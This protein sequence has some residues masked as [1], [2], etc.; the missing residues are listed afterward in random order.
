[1]RQMR[2]V[3]Y[4]VVI[5]APVLLYGVAVTLRTL[6]PAKTI[7]LTSGGRH[8]NR[9]SVSSYPIQD[10]KNPCGLVCIALVSHLHQRPVSLT[11]VRRLVPPD[12]LGRTS[13]NEL[14][15]GL[16]ALGFGVVG[17]KLRLEACQQLSVPLIIHEDG[18]HFAVVVPNATK[19][20]IFL[21]PPFAPTKLTL[22]AL[23]KRW[24]GN[25]IIVAKSVNEL[26]EVLR[27]L[28]IEPANVY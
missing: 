12:P 28:D 18:S 21:D 4:V 25:A 13:M 27:K 1:M 8:E 26:E 2:P 19:R 10:P 5:V 3:V 17:V 15:K 22:E 24:D 7:P 14:V 16:Q 23:A 9:R 11:E 20:V 6:A